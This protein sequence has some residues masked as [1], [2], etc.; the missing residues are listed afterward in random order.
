MRKCSLEPAG[1]NYRTLKDIIKKYEI[2]ETKLNENRSLS[3]SNV[4][5]DNVLKRETTLQEVFNGNRKMQSYKLLRRLVREGY[6]KFVCEECGITEWNNKPLSFHLHHINGNHEDN[7]LE[8]LAVLCPNCH[9]QTDNYTG[10]NIR[11]KPQKAIKPSLSPGT[12][13]TTRRK[14]SKE[15]VRLCK[16]CGRSIFS[17]D[18]EICS[19]CK[20]AKKEKAKRRVN[21]NYNIEDIIYKYENNK[22]SFNEIA[23]EYGLSVSVIINDY[24]TYKGIKSLEDGFIDRESLKKK[25]REESFL[26]ISKEIGVTDNA[27]R[28]WC[29]KFGLPSKKTEIKK[30]TN[31]EWKN[32]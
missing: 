2:D 8:N 16:E 3:Y 7:R 14:R 24:K 22:Q 26:K 5:K 13:N 29:V 30:Y 19:K 27:I 10:K 6:K 15:P 23:M 20:K 4:C 21:P 1:G 31:E 25:I 32:I 12:E 17:F 11:I 9:S 18:N 28:K